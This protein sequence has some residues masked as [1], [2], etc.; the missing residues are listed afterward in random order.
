M[1][2]WPWLKELR[3]QHIT[4]TW[5]TSVHIY[6]KILPCTTEQQIWKDTRLI[7]NKILPQKKEKYLSRSVAKLTKS[8]NSNSIPENL[9]WTN[10]WKVHQ[11]LSCINLSIFLLP[12]LPYLSLWLFLLVPFPSYT[13]Y[14]RLKRTCRVPGFELPNPN[15]FFCQKCLPK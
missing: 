10:N 12:R 5:W 11:E 4:P 14:I 6:F 3:S 8:S 13:L 9:N 1:W 7:D 15:Y 2:P